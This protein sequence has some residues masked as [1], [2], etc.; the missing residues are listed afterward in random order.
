[1]SLAKAVARTSVVRTA[2]M[3]PTND[4][5]VR[6]WN[7]DEDRRPRASLFGF[8][9]RFAARP[10]YD[11]DWASRGDWDERPSYGSTYR[12][13]CVR[14]CDGFYY[15]VS[16]SVTPDRFEHDAQVCERTC[17][18][19]AQLFVYPN[20]GGEIEDMQ[21]LRGRAYS[22]LRT[23]FLYRTTYVDSCKC[24]PRPWENAS[25]DRHRVYALEA[26]R[27]KGSKDAARELVA[28]QAKAR[29][30]ARTKPKTAALSKS[31]PVWGAEVLPTVTMPGVRSDQPM[32]LGARAQS[33]RRSAPTVPPSRRDEG[34]NR[35]VFDR[36]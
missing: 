25:L 17:G 3:T 6:R 36:W 12:T 2:V 34:W 7:P 10:D 15:P 26:A 32:A 21:D 1:M 19:Q 35:R 11:G 18:D 4:R 28:L 5:W 24:Q 8:S 13:M 33:N 20:P 31:Q 16:F 22:R 30:A 9:S 27:R 29:E 23:A 14:L